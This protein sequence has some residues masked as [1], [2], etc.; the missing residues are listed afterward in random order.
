MKKCEF[1][2]I[3]LI[4]PLLSFIALGHAADYVPVVSVCELLGNVE[5]YDRKNVEL[6]ADLVLGPHGGVLIDDHCNNNLG[7]IKLDISDNARKDPKV[8]SMIKKVMSHQAHGQV[9]LVG[10]FDKNSIDTSNGS[11]ILQTVP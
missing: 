6:H 7:A 11:F 10:S 3:C 2:S 9:V 8:T 1:R 5:K 4:L